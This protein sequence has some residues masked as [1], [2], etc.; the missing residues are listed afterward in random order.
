MI[1]FS[2]DLSPSAADASPKVFS[3]SLKWEEQVLA[4]VNR[5]RAEKGLGQLKLNPRA[6]AAAR[7]HSIDM[8]KRGYFSHRDLQG[9]L[10][11]E[12]LRQA[13]LG[14]WKGIAEN[15]AKCDASANPAQQAV[16]GWSKSP[17]HAKNMFNPDY[18]ET[19]IAAVL[20]QDGYVLFCQVFVVR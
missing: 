17:G 12:R 6:Q 1:V 14:P 7:N 13:H 8:A 19:G 18:N 16:V 20:D 15:I 3:S 10:V 4:Q 9:G 11:D 2:D 5:L